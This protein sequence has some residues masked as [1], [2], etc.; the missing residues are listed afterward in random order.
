MLVDGV[1]PRAN[2]PTVTALPQLELLLVRHGQSTGNLAARRAESAGVETIEADVRDADVPLSDTGRQQ[3]EALGGWLASLPADERPDAAWSSPFLRARDTAAIALE[4]A[5]LALPI[6][7]DERLRDRDLGVT[8]RLTSTGIRARF[9]QE[10]RR[11]KWLG[12]FYYRPPGGESWADVAFRVRSVLADLERQPAT[13]VL[14]TAHDVVVMMFRYVLEGLDE[15]GILEVGR[16]NGV[17]NGSVTRLVRE[18]PGRWRLADYN[19]VP[20]DAPR[21]K[22]A[23]LADAVTGDEQGQ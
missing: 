3:A 23:P 10:A 14:V 21:T 4:R 17:R 12:K 11:R 15:A 22:E 1:R 19:M 5:D 8:D 13:R 20:G 6:R 18:E 16:A 7:I 2:R 9:P